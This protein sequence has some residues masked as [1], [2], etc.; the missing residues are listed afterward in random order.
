MSGRRRLNNVSSWVFVSRV[1]PHPNLLP[2]GEG[3]ASSRCWGMERA[4]VVVRPG[5]MLV[6]RARG[7]GWGAGIAM[8]EPS[9]FRTGL[10]APLDA[11]QLFAARKALPCGGAADALAARKARPWGGR[12][13]PADQGTLQSGGNRV[14]RSA[15]RKMRSRFAHN[16]KSCE[17]PAM[18]KLRKLVLPL[19]GILA[20]NAF[21]VSAATPGD[22]ARGAAPDNAPR[23]RALLHARHRGPQGAGCGGFHPALAAARTD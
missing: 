15:Q 23:S 21:V 10:F 12:S 1:P 8:R 9:V 22:G 2:R 16:W 11:A 19:V 7:A 14:D 4:S 3:I 13:V 18:N 17:E 5:F 6:R 20:V